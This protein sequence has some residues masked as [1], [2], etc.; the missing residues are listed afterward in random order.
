MEPRMKLLCTAPPAS[1]F[2]IA[3]AMT[4]A[5][6]IAIAP[7]KME[8]RRAKTAHRFDPVD[9]PALGEYFFADLDDTQRH[10]WTRGV[11]HDD[12]HLRIRVV[13]PILQWRVI[14]V[15]AAR[16]ELDYAHRMEDYERQRARGGKI[17]LPRYTLDEPLRIIAE[18]GEMAAR[19]KAVEERDGVAVV[20]A[21]TDMM[22]QEVTVRAEA[23]KVRKWAAE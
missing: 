10:R 21:A 23:G 14:Q 15:F 8:L 13:E 1:V 19:F 22:G 18:W 7:R 9:M 16:I 17:E 4:D 20:I 2:A 6:I 12:R 11:W 3:D 5:G